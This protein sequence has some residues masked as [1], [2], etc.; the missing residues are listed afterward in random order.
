MAPNLNDLIGA[1]W[2]TSMFLARTQ[3]GVTIL[4]LVP[5]PGRGRC[6]KHQLAFF[7]GV[8]PAREC[9]GLWTAQ[10]SVGMYVLVTD[11]FDSVSRTSMVWI[12]NGDRKLRTVKSGTIREGRM[13]R[14]TQEIGHQRMFPLFGPRFHDPYG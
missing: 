1:L 12:S 2:C 13:R 6:N 4:F 14:V 5:E 7:F 8:L 10:Y 3:D 9:E 11:I